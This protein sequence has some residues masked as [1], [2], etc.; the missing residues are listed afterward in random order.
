MVE[1]RSSNAEA[2]DL[3]PIEALNVVFGLK[4]AIAFFG[5]S[6]SKPLSL[7]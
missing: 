7:S 6:L 3:N 1:H 2:V 4:F 5:I